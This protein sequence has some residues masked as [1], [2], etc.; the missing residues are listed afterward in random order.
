VVEAV[1]SV[2]TNYSRVGHL[3]EDIKVSLGNFSQWKIEFVRRG[4]NS[5]AHCLAKLAMR[6]VIERTWENEL[7]DCIRDTV[8][9]EQAALAD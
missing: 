9:L 2:A 1:K 4:S 7:L 5:A 6:N 3:V 8:L